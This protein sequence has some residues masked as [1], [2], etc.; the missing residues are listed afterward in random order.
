MKI[1][2]VDT[3]KLEYTHN[4]LNDKKIR[5]S[6][7]SII[8]LSKLLSK[9]GHSVSVFNHSKVEI[10][11]NMYSWQNISR[12]G[13]HKHDFDVVISNNDSEILSK[14]SCKK[15]YVL[16]HSILNFEKAIRKKQFFS[17]F[18]NKPRYLLLGNYHKKKM[19]KI[20]S[21]YGSH[22]INYGVDEIFENQVIPENFDK[23]LSFFT[24]RQD[25]N[26]DLLIEVWKNG[27]YKKRKKSKLYI[28]PISS[29]LTQF[30]IFNREMLNKKKFIN[31]IIK[32][33][34]IILPGHKAELC[35][36]AAMEASELC[37]PIVTMGIGSLSERVEHCVTGL[38]SKN[39]RT[40]VENILELYKNDILWNKIKYNLKLRRGSNSWDKVATDFNK[41]LKK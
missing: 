26:L 5:G 4:D 34:M 36:L 22:I 15:K 21:I 2:F 13:N 1:C 38:V 33:R 18:V 16:S 39:E 41:L 32:S 11:E 25:R 20:F 28:T 3:T 24:S 40:F 7:S 30:N 6:E 37:I 23:N 19:S 35:C 9:I 10:I 12:I 17:Y 29:N 14:F 8:N 27:V 31:D